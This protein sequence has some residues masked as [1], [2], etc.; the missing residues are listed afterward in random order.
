[1]FRG[2]RCQLDEVRTEGHDSERFA[3]QVSEAIPRLLKKPEAL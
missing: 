2:R 3:A 1:M